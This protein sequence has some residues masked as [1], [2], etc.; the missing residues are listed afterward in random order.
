[1]GQQEIIK[2]LAQDLG[3]NFNEE[4][5]EKEIIEILSIRVEQMLKGDPDLLMSYL[6]R[7]DVEEAKIQ[8]ALKT[9]PYPVHLTFAKLIWER[10]K[11]RM[12]FKKSLKQDPI[13]GWEF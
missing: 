6:Y 12:Q 5:D 9:S 4:S 11:I 3:L 1:M 2:V 10:Q 13:E 7:L 8:T